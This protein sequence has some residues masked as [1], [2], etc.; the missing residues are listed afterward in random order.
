[1]T[2]DDDDDEIDGGMVLR[3]VAPLPLATVMASPLTST[4][5]PGG[6]AGAAAL[7]HRRAV[8]WWKRGGRGRGE[9]RTLPATPMPPPKMAAGG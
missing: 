9:R 2:N 3:V 5:P 8:G 1:M 4:L 6:G 7:G